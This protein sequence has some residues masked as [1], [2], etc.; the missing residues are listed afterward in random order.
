M[1]LGY[2]DIRGVSAVSTVEPLGQR[3]G[4][5]DGGSLGSRSPVGAA[6]R[7]SIFELPSHRRRPLPSL[8]DGGP[9]G[10]GPRRPR[11]GRAWGAA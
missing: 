9:C 1:V 7:G 5:G 2:W 6:L 8:W 3:D 10:E 11:R 4:R